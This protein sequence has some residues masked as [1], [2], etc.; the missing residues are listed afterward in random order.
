MFLSGL[1]LGWQISIVRQGLCPREPPQA[2]GE[3]GGGDDEAEELVLWAERHVGP[4]SS[5]GDVA[6]VEAGQDAEEEAGRDEEED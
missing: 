3:D 1:G 4:A 5:A 6:V 2:G